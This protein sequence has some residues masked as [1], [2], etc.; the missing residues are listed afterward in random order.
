MIVSVIILLFVAIND[1]DKTHNKLA[2][3]YSNILEMP[4]ELK[5]SE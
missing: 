2:T 3:H 1:L 5:E 4:E